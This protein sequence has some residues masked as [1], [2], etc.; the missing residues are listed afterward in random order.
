METTIKQAE[1]E[2]TRTLHESQCLLKDYQPIKED[3]SKIR[4]MLNIDRVTDNDDDDETLINT[5][6]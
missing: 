6:Q 5:L 1:D 3:I 4:H 2:R